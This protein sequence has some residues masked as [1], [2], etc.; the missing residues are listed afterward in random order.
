MP[1]QPALAFDRLDHRRFLAAYIGA[2][3]APEI[4]VAGGDQ[5]F[6]LDERD[7]APQDE[8]RRRIFIAQIDEGLLRLDAPGGDQQPLEKLMRPAQQ[9]MAVLER[10]WLALVGIDAQIARPLGRPH[11]LP[12]LACRE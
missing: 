7:L 5:P 10:P 6:A 3:A 2:G 11:E 9:I 8:M 12:F 4:D 1:R